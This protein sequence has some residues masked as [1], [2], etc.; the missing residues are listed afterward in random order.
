MIALNDFL[1]HLLAILEKELR[2]QT[3]LW[4]VA[5]EKRD[6]LL[7]NQLEELVFLLEKEM[8]LV[9]QVRDTEKQ[10]TDVWENM[11]ERCNLE[12]GELNLGRIIELSPP[13]LALKF[14]EVQ[15]ELKRVVR[16]LREVNSQNA[17]LIDDTLR[18]ID[19]VFSLLMGEGEN[20]FYSP[21]GKEKP[22]KESK[23]ILI[24]GVI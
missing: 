4:Q 3:E 21:R 14:G 20:S 11:V 10:L 8:N 18:Y 15:R 13:D 16:A 2:L 5:E 7:K 6:L 24:N 19:V 22:A 9:I 23:G 12:P 1:S 17:I